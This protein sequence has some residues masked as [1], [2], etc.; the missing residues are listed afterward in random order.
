M[1]IKHLTTSLF[2]EKLLSPESAISIKTAGIALIDQN[3]SIAERIVPDHLIYFI[4]DGTMEASIN[5][6]NFKLKAGNLLWVQPDVSQKFWLHPS[7]KQTK[8]FFARFHV[9]DKADYFGMANQHLLMADFYH[10]QN[11]FHDFLIQQGEPSDLNPYIQKASITIILCDILKEPQKKEIN[12]DGLKRYQISQ[13]QK[14]IQKNINKR[15][16]SADLAK[17]LNMN[18]DYFSRQ[19][20]KSFLQT[21]KEYFK[22]ER[23]RHAANLLMETNMN[24][25]E[26]ASFL[27]Y[28]D[29]F[30]FSQQFKKA[31]HISP[32]NFRKKELK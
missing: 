3:W 31:Y 8:V 16:S 29:V 28:T 19:F 11:H 32:N 7:Q 15:F 4:A 22:Q 20:K 26:I 17:E 24:I 9:K 30:Q 14:Y 12:S 5:K 23:I 18:Q 27:G 1:P 21:P 2:L 10:L 25:N 6:N 13:I